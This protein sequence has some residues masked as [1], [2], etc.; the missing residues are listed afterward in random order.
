MTNGIIDRV[1]FTNATF[2]GAKFVNAVITGTIFEGAD[3]SE[4]NF[5]D[6]VI[7]ERCAAV[8]AA[9]GWDVGRWPGGGAARTAR[10]GGTVN[11]RSVLA[12]PGGMTMGVCRQQRCGPSS[13]ASVWMWKASVCI[14]QV[15]SLLLIPAFAAPCRAAGGEDVKRL[16]NN[17]TLTGESRYQVGCR[18]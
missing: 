8:P 2:K 10:G 17:P 5:E 16:C 9:R 12:C 15:C 4:T 14:L 18:T 1:D 3:L 11:V 7:G 6:A 13:L